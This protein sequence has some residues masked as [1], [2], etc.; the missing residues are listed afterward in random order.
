MIC[1]PAHHRDVCFYLSSTYN[2]GTGVGHNCLTAHRHSS[3]MLK[4][5]EGSP[6]SSWKSAA[7]TTITSASVIPFAGCQLHH[8]VAFRPLLLRRGCVPASPLL[9]LE[10]GVTAAHRTR[11][12]APSRGCECPQAVSI[13]TKQ[14]G[15]CPANKPWR[16]RALSSIQRG[17]C[18]AHVSGV[19]GER[20]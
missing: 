4:G 17:F 6:G 11:M 7:V 13:T 9:F 2:G 12:R 20:R 1:I 3:P 16:D 5:W 8:L 14:M 18:S 15:C 10:G 19:R